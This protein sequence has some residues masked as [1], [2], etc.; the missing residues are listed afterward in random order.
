MPDIAILP[1]R[2]AHRDEIMAVLETANMHHIP[3][4]EMPALDLRHAWV[5][6]MTGRVVGF[7][8]LTMLDGCRAKTTLLA[9]LPECRRYGIGRRLQEKRML[10]ALDLGATTL[11]TNADRPET[12]AWYRKHFG[13]REMGHLKKAHEFGLPDVDQWTPLATDLVAWR[14]QHDR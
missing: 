1:A 3:S 12:I 14:E 4:A 9:V 8:G 10:A 11:I 5:A 13:Y 2:D 6:V 7:C